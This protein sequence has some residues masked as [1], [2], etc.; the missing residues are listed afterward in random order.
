MPRR[1]HQ[2]ILTI[3]LAAIT[4]L[5]QEAAQLRAETLEGSLLWEPAP[6]MEW[7]ERRGWA[8]WS[9][10]EIGMS[11]GPEPLLLAPPARTNSS[12]R[13]VAAQQELPDLMVEPRSSGQ[14]SE[15]PPVVDDPTTFSSC[16][17]CGNCPSCRA[18]RGS[19]VSKART[20]VGRFYDSLYT[21]IT[22]PPPCYEPAWS[23]LGNAAL[24][25]DPIRPQTQQRFRW[26]SGWGMGYPDRNEFF[27]ARSGGGGLGPAHA[28]RTI[29]Y[30]ELSMYTETALGGFGAF[31]ETP[32]RS[33]YP[34]NAGHSAGFGDLIVGTKS[35]LHDSEFLLITFQFKTHI[36][37][38]R[39]LIG[40]GVGHVSLEPS[41]LIGVHLT[42]KTYVQAQ[43]AEWIPLG[44]NSSYAG[45]L[46]HYHASLNRCL[47]QHCDSQFIGSLEVNGWSFQDGAYTD[48]ST[49]QAIPSNNGNYM[50][51]GPSFRYVWSETFDFAFGTT[52]GI[53]DP[54][55]AERLYRSEFRIRY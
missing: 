35:L 24:F 31:I 27:W 4:L 36:P 40:V 37:I 51:A 34:D 44:G 20:Q 41:L 11:P 25:V 50:S 22:Y 28:A 17:Q 49:G 42:P 3:L 29:D 38:G 45:A 52:F 6:A 14:A 15:A 13:L 19:R 16:N 23:H 39:P 46:M 12:I 32:Y 18:G 7:F 33:I 53:S 9:A 5:L 2:P 47:W 10:A 54:S 21:A 55:F 48:P 43:F 1:P 26:D 8:D 30:H